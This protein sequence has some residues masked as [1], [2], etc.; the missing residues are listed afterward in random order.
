[1]T[2]LE[3]EEI[4][5]LFDAIEQEHLF[6]FVMLAVNTLSRPGAILELTIDQCDLTRNLIHLNPEGRLQTK[7]RRPIVPISG[8]LKPFIEAIPSGH[9]VQFR[10]RPIQSIRTAWQKTIRHAGLPTS[11]S[12]MTLRRTMA[13]ELRR[14]GVQPWDLAGLMGHITKESTTEIYAEYDPEYLKQAIQAIDAYL[15]EVDDRTKRNSLRASC[16][17]VSCPRNTWPRILR[18][19][20]LHQVVWLGRL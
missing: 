16:V 11:I 17:L 13:R 10:G 2:R 8:T 4:A 20:S 6:M 19:D 9:L 5:R 12:P 14:R 1:M 18:C 3:V 7:K 15:K